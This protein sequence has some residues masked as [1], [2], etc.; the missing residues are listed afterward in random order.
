MLRSQI[1]GKWYEQRSCAFS[2]AISSDVQHDKA[3]DDD[4]E[5]DEG[6]IQR[7]PASKEDAVGRGILDG[8]VPRE[9]GGKARRSEEDR[10][11]R[12]ELMTVSRQGMSAALL[13][14]SNVLNSSLIEVE[15]VIPQ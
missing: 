9:H 15:I 1:F 7:V 3:A 10:E 13:L 2:G 6:G 5:L 11:L 8:L 12:S 4:Q 14:V